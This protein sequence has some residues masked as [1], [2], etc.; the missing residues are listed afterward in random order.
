M[1]NMDVK[2]YIQNPCGTLSIPYWKAKTLTIPGSMQI[3]HCSDW[4]GQYGDYQRFFRIKHDL[5]NLPPINFDY[6][7]LSIDGQAAELSEMMNAC[8]HHENIVVTKEDIMR[9]KQHETFR[10]DLC[11]Y[12]NSAGGKMAA[13]GIAEFDE[14]CREGIIEWVQVL[15][16]YRGS[17]LGKKIVDVLLSRLKSIGADYATVSGNLDNTSKPLE[18]YRKCGFTGDDIWY[19]CRT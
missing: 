17:G 8:Y 18:L 10:E 15:P 3:I 19:I 7:T 12:I 14:T 9:W 4:D 16:E 2:E 11:I 13:S 5:K 1:R 6:D